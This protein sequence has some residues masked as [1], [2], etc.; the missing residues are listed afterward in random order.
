MKKKFVTLAISMFIFISSVPVFASDSEEIRFRDIPWGASYTEVSQSMPEFDWN[1]MAFEEMRTYPTEEIITD[2]DDYSL[3]LENGYINTFVSPASIKKTEVAGY[4]TSDIN[5]FFAY[6]PVNETLT[7]NDSDTAFYGAR[8]IFNPENIE[9]MTNDLVEKLSSLYGD[10][11]DVQ[12]ETN[13]M[14]LREK[15]IYWD[16]ANNTQ[17][18][19]RAVDSSTDTSG[20]FDNELWISYVWKDGDELLK[21]ADQCVSQSNSDAEATIYGNNNTNGL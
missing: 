7:R 18:V 11:D 13:Y 20:L 14:N 8:Y 21:Q 6:L 5:L 16:G 3:G 15:R 17:V 10:Y 2:V 1:V 12:E 19:I 9:G 4:T